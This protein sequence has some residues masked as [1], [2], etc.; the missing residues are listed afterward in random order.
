MGKFVLYRWLLICCFGIAAGAVHAQSIALKEEGSF[1]GNL[2]VL[3]Q[4]STSPTA[5]TTLT[6]FQPIWDGQMAAAEK[7]KLFNIARNIQLKNP[8]FLTHIENLLI[9][10]TIAVR[11]RKLP[12]D[13]QAA[14][15]SM[16]EATAEEK[17]YASEALMRMLT[18]LKQF[19]A[20]GVMYK[21]TASTVSIP[22][23]TKF[24]FEY[25]KTGDR[26]AAPPDTE[27]WMP[28]EEPV[29]QNPTPAADPWDDSNWDNSSGWDTSE[30]EVAPEPSKRMRPGQTA[31]IFEKPQMPVLGGGFIKIEPTDLTIRTSADTLTI[32]G[33]EG[34][35]FIMQTRFIGKGGKTDWTRVGLPAN[36]ITCTF[37]EYHF[38]VRRPT[39]KA[40]FARLSYPAKTDSVVL[41]VYEFNSQRVAQR[42]KATYPRFQSYYANI[43]VKGIAKD[44]EYIGGFSLIGRNFSSANFSNRPSTVFIKK[45]GELKFRAASRRNFNFTDSTLAN[46]ASEVVIYLNNGQDSVT[47][48]GVMLRYNHGAGKLS[49]RKERREYGMA[50]FIDTYHKVEMYADRLTWDVTQD[51][52]ILDLTVSNK[53]V[54]DTNRVAL[55][56]RSLDYFSDMVYT[57]EVRMK[58]TFNPVGIAVAHAKRVKSNNFTALELADASKIPVRNVRLAMKRMDKMGFLSYDDST[59]WIELKRKAILYANAS[60]G[61]VDYD[62]LELRSITEDG[63]N[64]VLNLSNNEMNVKGVAIFPIW[65]PTEPD[66][67]DTQNAQRTK[68]RDEDSREGVWAWP[69][70][71]TVRIR[72]NREILVSGKVEILKRKRIKDLYYGQDMRFSYD[73]FL[74]DMPKVDSIVMAQRDSL[75]FVIMVR[76]EKT[77]RDEVLMMQNKIQAASGVLYVANPKNRSGQMRRYANEPNDRYPEF[78]AGAGAYIA[79]EGSQ[80]EGSQSYKDRVRF[81]M[82]AFNLKGSDRAAGAER[83]DGTFK[84]EGIFPD[85]QET[86]SQQRDG[87]F[88]FVHKTSKNL[89]KFPKGYPLYTD[90]IGTPRPTTGYF[91][92]QIVLNNDGIRGNGNISYLSAELN[93]ADFMY[94][95]DSVTTMGEAAKNRRKEHNSGRI[96]AGEYLGTSYP[97]V[98]MTDFQL[99]WL[100]RQ[101]SMML[102]TTD[103]VNQPFRMYG[104]T[105]R[106]DQRSTFKGTLT[107]TPKILAGNGIIDNKGAIAKSA[108]FAFRMDGY[109]ARHAEY[110][111]IKVNGNADNPAMLATN[112]RIDYDLGS[113]RKAKIETEVAG[114]Q[115]FRF[116]Y[117]KYKTSLGSAIWN[118][119]N[120]NVQMNMPEG[121]DNLNNS[122]FTSTDPKRKGL[123]FKGASAIYDLKTYFLNVDGVPEIFSVDAHII[124][125]GNK[126]KILPE[127]DM[128]PL[129]DCQVVVQAEN[130]YHK[131]R[132]GN[133]RVFSK[134]EYSGEAIYDY[135][136]DEDKV[137]EIPMQFNPGLYERN[138]NREAILTKTKT[139]ISEDEQL[140]WKAGTIFRG[141]VMMRGDSASLIF[142]GEYRY[143]ED[144]ES[145]IWF[146]AKGVS[147]IAVPTIEEVQNQI[148]GAGIFINE[149]SKNIYA[150]YRAP[151]QNK[152]DRAIFGTQ[153][154]IERQEGDM[155]ITE[156]KG[157]KEN[158]VG[159][160]FGFS[161]SKGIAEFEGK[162]EFVKP[163][164]RFAI[165][166]AAKGSAKYN[167]NNYSMQALM[168]IRLEEG[169][170]DIFKDIARHIKKQVDLDETAIPNNEELLYKLAN[171]ISK[172]DLDDFQ[173]R[174]TR[175]RAE[176]SDVLP[177]PL[178]MHNVNMNWSE[179]QRAFYSKGKIHLSNIFKENIN[180][181]IDGYIEIPMASKQ[182]CNIYLQ[183]SKG[184]WYYFSYQDND[185]KILTSDEDLNKKIADPKS[186]DKFKLAE[187][188]E[189]LNFVNTFR[190]IYLQ[191][192]PIEDVASDE[193]DEETI[194]KDGDE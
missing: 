28:Q 126:V 43:P 118:F 121:D 13:Q 147:D 157:R 57:Q 104:E 85:F 62:N 122:V 82:D 23:T 105:T 166:A 145:Q 51:S 173:R 50:P 77:R 71:S 102:T 107:L 79:F 37:D 24:S 2:E 123:S 177:L 144:E 10:S 156:T 130:Q 76:N 116:P 142:N 61:Q 188:S 112:V 189:R 78:R 146:P 190:Q 53:N 152:N 159:N 125:A 27:E 97:A 44:V 41:G 15:L 96:L 132:K 127:G 59:D 164:N 29:A 89:D 185:V 32:R 72:Q 35:L 169:K 88:G 70:D 191:Q 45:N 69:A 6:N 161:R 141:E 133:I 8:N 33:T 30:P 75:G 58:S 36:E 22:M 110:F 114:E 115:S 55:Y 184:R 155:R 137:F 160:R 167:Q 148:V 95:P 7:T 179:K 140:I 180:L 120:N 98:D 158:Y 111:K 74:V 101:D 87:S 25:A 60:L 64:I 103:T 187:K 20:E 181:V 68:S 128:E 154:G 26:T 38:D 14:M 54:S 153:N 94:Y 124:P 9:C 109:V 56:I 48:P 165:L 92:G 81:D 108:D 66:Q 149:R 4:R 174:I 119:D 3:Y 86:I 139:K 183:V 18:I 83:F 171:I 11:D 47:H 91:E 5:K 73:S 42:E 65:R 163:D 34:R 186:K 193:D 84:T 106:E 134:H 67:Y 39:L 90:S 40:E 143:L 135:K 93:S 172:S 138:S 113:E 16:I 46:P 1:I 136:N 162:I 17:K 19:L 52:M 194:E 131:L 99:K 176:I 168:A 151:L 100:A 12:A 178:V 80:I 63:K 129:L 31:I 170:G 150:I 21:S 175:G 182:V 49:A 117:T 192:G